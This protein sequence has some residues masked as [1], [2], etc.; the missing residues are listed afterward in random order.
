MESVAGQIE[1]RKTKVIIY[2]ELGGA[3]VN[4]VSLCASPLCTRYNVCTNKYIM[5][6]I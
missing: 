4:Y 2:T 6:I 1:W 3:S 5:C